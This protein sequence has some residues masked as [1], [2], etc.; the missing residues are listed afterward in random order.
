MLPHLRQQFNSRFSSEKYS[1]F[2]KRMNALC[3]APISFRI[4]ETPCFFPKK[5]VD[6]MAEAGKQLILQLVEN[7][8][9]RTESRRAIPAEY[10]VPNETARPLFVQADFGLVEANGVYSPRLVE[11]QAFPT[12][13]AFQPVLAQQYQEVFQIATTASYLLGNITLDGYQALVRRAI[14]GEQDPENVILLEI[15][16]R[17]QKTLP[18]FILTDRLCGIKTVCVR[19]VVRKS[20]KLYYPV[21]GRLVPIH[22][23]YNRAVVDEL[24]RRKPPMTFRFHDQVDVEWAGHP[25]WFFRISKFSIPYLQHPTVPAAFFL[26]R[27]E[28]IP[29]HLDRYVLKPL[30]SF[31]GQGVIIGPSRQ[32]IDAI[33]KTE[34]SRYILQERLEFA[35][36]IATP[37]GLTKAEIRVMYLWLDELRAVTTIVR[38]GRGLMMGV[39]YN[40]DMEWVGA[41]VAFCE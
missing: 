20:N 35:P 11:V 14:L 25:N 34:R 12:L 28:E 13:Y 6:A 5:L 4:S 9:Y 27:I 17:N 31:A 7:P 18:D 26:D 16:P 32:D 19:D 8:V 39:D 29:R 37:H 1:R 36:V 10:D 38:M 40:K 22:R 15:D 30:F 41:S 2:L 24:I 23:I 33:P 3:G 21:D